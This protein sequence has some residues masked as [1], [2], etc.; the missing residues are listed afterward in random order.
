[1]TRM[2]V[3]VSRDRISIILHPPEEEVEEEEEEEEEAEEE[4]KGNG[5]GQP[6]VAA[7]DSP[8][9][10]SNLRASL[11]A[12][13]IVKVAFERNVQTER[14]RS[15]AFDGFYAP[16]LCLLCSAICMLRVFLPSGPLA[17]LWP[18]EWQCNGRTSYL[19]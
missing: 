6:D 16:R 2:R 13:K 10:D 19:H 14:P 1:M 8:P 7:L 18:A 17:M 11:A 4:D 5:R 9:L 15:G 3:S 12:K